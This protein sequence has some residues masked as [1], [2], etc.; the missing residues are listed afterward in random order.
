M[1]LSLLAGVLAGMAGMWFFYSGNRRAINVIREEKQRL[2][3]EK[4]IVVEFMHNMVAAVGEGSE[5]E[6]LFQ[7]II[8]AAILSTGA[9]SACIF[10]RQPDGRLKGIAVEG[11]FPPQRPIPPDS[12][13]GLGTR[14]RFIESVLKSESFAPGEGLIGEVAQSRR[15]VLIRDARSDPRVVAHLD[16]ALQMRSLVVAPILFQDELIGVLAVAN[17]ADGTDFNETDF[18]LVES[19]AEQVG[20]AVHN[21]DLV[22]LQIEKNRLDIDIELAGN[23]QGLLLPRTLPHA[24]RVD[25]AAR[26][27]PAQKIGGDLYDAFELGGK[28]MGLAVA[29]VS[30]KGIPASIVMAICRTHLR[31]FAHR[32]DSPADVLR[33]VNDGLQHSLRRDMFITMVY[34]VID[35][36]EGR[37]RLARAGHEPPFFL[38]AEAGGAAPRRLS[39][40]GMALGMVPP[41]IFDPSIEDAVLPFSKGDTLL[42]FT[43]GLTESPNHAGVEYSAARLGEALESAASLSATEMVESLMESVRRFTGR[44][45]QADDLTL[46]AVKPT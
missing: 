9:T 13:P 10:E 45:N 12:R 15:A 3:Q 37:L 41:R 38:P 30:G 32:F 44:G 20:M 1:L 14:A 5:R 2:G 29:D 39:P 16:P 23:I 18:S 24:G 7:R 4:Q 35:L 25:I 28:R 17:P 21:S 26:Y 42:L 8:H 19:L 22:R 33:A 11:L 27:H 43:D 34:A 31:H 36:E 46:I 6:A 40:R